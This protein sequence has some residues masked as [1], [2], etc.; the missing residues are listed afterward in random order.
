MEQFEEEVL[1]QAKIILLVSDQIRRGITMEDNRVILRSAV[2]NILNALINKEL[3]H[4]AYFGAKPI[5][6]YMSK[7]FFEEWSRNP[8][9][10]N[11]RITGVYEHRTPMKVIASYLLIAESENEVVSIIRNHAVCV[12]ITHDENKSLNRDGLKD[13]L[14][15]TGDRY[16]DA[17]IELHPEGLIRF[18]KTSRV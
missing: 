7:R 1:V 8:T 18:I 3:G 17:G 12:W 13:R 11:L 5:A 14:P 9:Q 10:E 6:R 16:K 2:G 15:S 4:Q